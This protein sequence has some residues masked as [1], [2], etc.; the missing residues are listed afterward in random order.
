M[1]LVLC[2]GVLVHGVRGS[3]DLHRGGGSDLCG[4]RGPSPPWVLPPPRLRSLTSKF[5]K[6]VGSG[7]PQGGEQL[8]RPHRSLTPPLWRSAEPLPPC[9]S[10]ST[11]RTRRLC[12]LVEAPLFPQVEMWP[13]FFVESDSAGIFYLLHIEHYGTA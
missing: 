2:V 1:C 13:P 8:R 10:T 12:P 3:A 11:P 6:I 5:R 7:D 4:R 9:T